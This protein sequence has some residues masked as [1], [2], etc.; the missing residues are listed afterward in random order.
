MSCILSNPN[1]DRVL[2]VNLG[3]L[4]GCLTHEEGIRENINHCCEEAERKLG[5]GLRLW[6]GNTC[7]PELTMSKCKIQIYAASDL[8]Y[9]NLNLRNY[10][11]NW[12]RTFEPS[13]IHQKQPTALWGYSYNMSTQASTAITSPAAD[14]VLIKIT[15]QMRK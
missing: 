10:R 1:C 4:E 5:V 3:T 15:S 8:G 6:M 13:E 7:S 11:K 2:S 9:R 12:S 14:K